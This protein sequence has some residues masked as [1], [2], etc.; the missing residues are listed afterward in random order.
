LTDTIQVAWNQPGEHVIEV[1]VSS[2]GV[3]V[4]DSRAIMVSVRLYLP[5]ILNRTE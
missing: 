4:A 1:R 3:E 2:L 5:A